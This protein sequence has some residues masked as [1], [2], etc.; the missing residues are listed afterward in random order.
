M[1]KK[2]LTPLNLSNLASDPATGSEGDLYFNTTNDVVKIYVNGEWTELQGG[3]GGSVIYSPEQP[4]INTLDVGTIWMDS[5]AE[6]T[7][8]GNTADLDSY[9]TIIS[10]S[11]TYATKAELNNINLTSTIN[12]ASAAAYASASA[13]TDS[14]IANFEALPNQSGNAGK[15]LSTDGSTTSWE[16]LDLNSAIQTASAAAAAYTDSELASIDLSAAIVTASAAAAAYTD[17]ELASIDLSATIQ[18]AS[19][20]AVSYLVDGAPEAL[21]TLNELSAALNDDPNIINSLLT[22][23]QASAT[24]L[25]LSSS[26]SFYRWTKTY[27]ASA[28]VISGVDDN[29]ISLSYNSGYI[30]LF[31][32]GVM[33]DPSEYTATSGSAITVS[34]PVL[35]GEVVDIFAFLN[36]TSVNTYS[37]AQIDNKYNN[38]TR[39]KKVYTIPGNESFTVTNDGSGAYVVAGVQN[40]TF[41]LVKGNTY[42]FVVNASGHPFWIQTVSG[43]YSSGN[44]YS[45]GTTNLGTDSGT[46]T[47]TVPTN[48]PDTL[49]Y[50]C[51]FHSS[52]QGTINLIDPA[53]IQGNDDNSL[54]LSYTSGYEQVYLNGILIT[55]IADYARTSASVIT[56]G[57]GVVTNDVIEIINTQPFN[58]ADVYNTSQSDNRYL[59]QS[60]AS[61][62][63]LT[64][65][66]GI[67]AATASATYTPLSSPVTSFKNKI[68]NSEFDIWQRGT[69]FNTNGVY[70]ADRWQL[71]FTGTSAAVTTSRVSFT[72]GNEISNYESEFF[73]RNAVTGGTGTSALSVLTQKIEDVRTLAGQTITVSFWAKTASGTPSIGLDLYQEFG[74]GGSATV[75]G[76]GAS[77]FQLS[78][79]WQRFT[80]TLTLASI[81]GKT[82]GAGSLLATRFWFSSGSDYNSLNDSLGIQSNTFDIWGVQVEKGSIATE[83]EQ[84][85]IGDELRL[86]QRYYEKSYNLNTNPGTITDDGQIFWTPGAIASG[87]ITGVF[88][89]EYKVSK[90]ISN[91]TV[92]YYSPITGTSGVVRNR[93]NNSTSEVDKNTGLGFNSLGENRWHTNFGAGVGATEYFNDDSCSVKFHWTSSAEL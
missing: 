70:T 68:I 85:F 10:A 24:Y 39:W 21:N 90:R 81:S 22:A 2:F 64:Q 46:I 79:S 93:K 62:T 7:S 28:S 55:P 25:P 13:Y 83:F 59:T 11:G 34:T 23:S 54:P 77:K 82:I 38:L 30:Q 16:L 72:P 15:Y 57:S 20:A 40:P 60:S 63:Y 88:P 50:A 44:V 66:N 33:L 31:I 43:G 73:I 37:Q 49:Y 6:I 56:L 32:N 26:A 5:N 29:S 87:A 9:L 51:Q 84:R 61:T 27:S 71:S 58:V 80:K 45:T 53:K 52:M 89:V 48:A 69:S 91:C 78:T 47:W 74:S 41:N 67:T 36:S 18:T 35:S 3:G 86:C 76:Q 8:I 1:A 4:D 92:T 19:A 17:S 65:S 75:G 42:T 12:T 14:A